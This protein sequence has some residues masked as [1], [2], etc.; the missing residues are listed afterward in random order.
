MNGSARSDDYTIGGSLALQD[1]LHAL[2]KEYEDI[3]SYSVKGRSM[4]VPPMEIDVD[5][6][7]W[8]ASAHRFASR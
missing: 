2:I 4:D 3:F 1:N 8:E 5:E 6:K 7:L